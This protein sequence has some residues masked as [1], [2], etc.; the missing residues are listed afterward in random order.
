M[1]RK[2]VESYS[3]EEA[4]RALNKK[5]K[6]KVAE[7]AGEVEYDLD[8]L[9]DEPR[10]SSEVAKL[11]SLCKQHNIILIDR[12]EFDISS[13]DI[14]PQNS[15]EN[16]LYY[17]L[18]TDADTDTN[19][20]VIAISYDDGRIFIEEDYK[21]IGMEEGTEYPNAE[22]FISDYLKHINDVTETLNKKPMK[23]IAEAVDD[24]LTNIIK[25]QDAEAAAD[26]ILKN[27]SCA[28]PKGDIM[29]M[30]R[31]YGCRAQMY[32]V[33]ALDKAFKTILPNLTKWWTASDEYGS[34]FNAAWSMLLVDS[35]SNIYGT[36]AETQGGPYIFGLGYVS[37]E[38][39]TQY[40][41]KYPVDGNYTPAEF[42]ES[43]F[44][45]W[46]Y[47]SPVS[48]K[49]CAECTAIFPDVYDDDN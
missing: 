25:T 42:D 37:I 7:S 33:L 1:K 2:I 34:A 5:P 24:D 48:Q 3:I 11:E 15:Y 31:A 40:L 49:I 32:D 41:A 19:N 28:D 21:N 14:E 16:P 17:E 23:K 36:W 13:Y 44:G 29:E 30:C 39:L 46:G 43:K 47:S 35:D 8:F 6:Q 26:W 9:D 22:A 45:R 10:P 38:E 18:D 20:V 27:T 4:F 12:S